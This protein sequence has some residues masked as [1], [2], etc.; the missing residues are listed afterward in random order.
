MYIPAHF[1][2][3]PEGVQNLLARPGAANLV[4]MTDQGLLATLL[5]FASGT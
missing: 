4:T 2:A 1:A 5:P 3:T